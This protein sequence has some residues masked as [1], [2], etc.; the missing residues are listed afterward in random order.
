MGKEVRLFRKRKG[1][2]LVEL[3]IGRDDIVAEVQGRE[4]KIPVDTVVLAV[5]CRAN[6]E[7]EI[8]LKEGH[9]KVHTIG[10]CRDPANI[11]AAVHQGFR[12]ICEVLETAEP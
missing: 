2:N 1:F 5:G 3:L 7:L 11:K 8:K 9:Y 6:T 4:L 12:I 10:D